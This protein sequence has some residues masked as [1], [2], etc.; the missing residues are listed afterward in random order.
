[1]AKNG[2]PHYLYFKLKLTTPIEMKTHFL[3]LTIFFL[4]SLYGCGDKD[5][6][7]PDSSPSDSGTG[8]SMARFTI[9]GNYLFTVDNTKMK[10]FSIADPTKPA[11][12][13]TTDLGFGI[14][15]IFL[16]KNNTLFLGSQTGMYIYDVTNPSSPSRI[17]YYQHIYSCDPVVANDSFAYVTLHSANSRC[18]RN[19]NE[20]QVIDITKLA[21][22]FLVKSYPLTSPRGLGIDKK[23]LFICDDGLK[24]YNAT[25]SKNLVLKNKFNIPALDVIPKDSVLMVLASDGLVQYLYKDDKI[26]L[27]SKLLTQS[28]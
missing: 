8:G 16:G 9:S 23:L 6:Y 4:F 7:N 22:P 14:E 15:T 28:N 1:M 27:L 2:C 10:V 24:V 11:L 17:C 13:N 19:T 18:G 20:L 21:S 25:S 26:Q 12:L 3:Y 5:T